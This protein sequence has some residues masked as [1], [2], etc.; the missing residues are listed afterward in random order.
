MKNRVFLK[1]Q[2]M[3]KQLIIVKDWLKHHHG[4][5]IPDLEPVYKEENYH[6]LLQIKMAIL[7][8]IRY[9][10]GITLYCL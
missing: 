5:I 3:L 2:D 7:A 8:E 6:S 10:M 9:A 4:F 1:P